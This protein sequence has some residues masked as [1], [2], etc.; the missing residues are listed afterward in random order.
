M[1]GARLMVGAGI[2]WGAAAGIAQQVLAQ[3]N[4]G[5]PHGSALS[6]AQR[7]DMLDQQIRL[8]NRLTPVPSAFW[9]ST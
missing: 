8:L 6:L 9:R 7:L 4:G 1:K 3:Q 5:S 2:L